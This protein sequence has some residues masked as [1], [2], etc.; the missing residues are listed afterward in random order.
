MRFHHFS[1]VLKI[2]E[3]TGLPISEIALL[4]E[5]EKSERSREEVMEQMMRAY[6]VMEES[7][8]LGLTHRGKSPSGL[9]G[10]DAIKIVESPR[11]V[12][13]SMTADAV[14][15]ALGVNEVSASQGK[16]V[17][18][19]TAGSCGILPGAV[20]AFSR[21]RK[22]S[23]EQT[24]MAL[25]TAGAIGQI[26]E[27]NACVSGA[28]GGCQAE[29]GSAA[30]MA[31]GAVAEMAGGSPKEVIQAATLAIKNL[32][33]LA[34]DPVAGLV[35]VPCVKRNGIL[36]GYSFIAAEMA[37]CGI[38]SAIPADEVVE[39]MYKIGRMMPSAIRETAEGGLAVT[40]T[41]LAWKEKITQ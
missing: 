14:A 34:C 2:H 20:I 29:C 6:E 28:E 26:I 12:I 39:A 41:G 35:E 18:C 23:K 3:E 22:I 25:F 1:D 15:I 36:A 7:A 19:P 8:D 24:C 11:R 16:I 33:G 27:E 31:A 10:G 40:P 4:R 17:A 13:D 32:L 21:H 9:S 37:L 30:A 38:E 5:M